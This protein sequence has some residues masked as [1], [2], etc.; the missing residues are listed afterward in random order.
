MRVRLTTL[1]KILYHVLFLANQRIPLTIV[2]LFRRCSAAV[3]ESPLLRVRAIFFIGDDISIPDHAGYSRTVILT[4]TE[5]LLIPPTR[6]ESKRDLY[7]PSPGLPGTARGAVPPET[8]GLAIPE[9]LAQPSAGD[10]LVRDSLILSDFRHQ[11]RHRPA[12]AIV[13][14]QAIRD[15]SHVGRSSRLPRPCRGCSV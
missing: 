7:L 8:A 3:M 1:P 2:G 6:W 10:A 15:Q 4:A 12:S 5:P 14:L 9:C 13:L 11:R